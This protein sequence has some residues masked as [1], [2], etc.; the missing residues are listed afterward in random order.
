MY[1]ILTNISNNTTITTI[2]LIIGGIVIGTMLKS[3]LNEPSKHHQDD[4]SND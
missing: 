1:N 2:C 3:M 4:A